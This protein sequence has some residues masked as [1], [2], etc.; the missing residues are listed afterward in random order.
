MFK[1]GER[2]KNETLNQNSFVRFVL[3]GSVVVTFELNDDD[4]MEL[5][6]L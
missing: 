6:H 1:G 5:K 4:V 3:G 2:E